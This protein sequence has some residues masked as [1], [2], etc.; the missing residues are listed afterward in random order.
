RVDGFEARVVPREVRERDALL[1]DHELGRREEHGLELVLGT[2]PRRA[3]HARLLQL[4]EQLVDRRERALARTGHGAPTSRMHHKRAR[5]RTAT[6]GNTDD[7]D[8][9]D[10]T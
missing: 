5:A 2:F 9:T 6:D 1:P 8:D 7:T 4:R 10:D 3:R